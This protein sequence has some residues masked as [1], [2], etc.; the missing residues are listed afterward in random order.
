MLLARIKL[1]NSKLL[2]ATVKGHAMG[3]ALVGAGIGGGFKETTKLKPMNCKQAVCKDPIVWGKTFKE[4][5][6]RM[7]KHS[8]W[9]A[10]MQNDL[11]GAAKVIASTWTCKKKSN[12]EHRARPN[13]RAFIQVQGVHCKP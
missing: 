10:V 9:Q 13:A 6:A 7:T 1:D 3:L 8:A 4:E 5:H 12:G 11:I 2:G